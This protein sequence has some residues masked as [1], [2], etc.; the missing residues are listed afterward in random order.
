MVYQDV[1]FKV[2]F[3]LLALALWDSPVLGSVTMSSTQL[4]LVVVK[5]VFSRSDV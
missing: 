1:L 2:L 5:F 3:G 4:L